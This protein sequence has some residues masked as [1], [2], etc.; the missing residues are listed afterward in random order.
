MMLP[1]ALA[2]ALCVVLIVP[3]RPLRRL[4]PRPARG[5][6]D[7]RAALSRLLRRPAGSR[8]VRG[9]APVAMEFL[10]VCLDAGAPV[11][12]A[13]RSVVEVSPEVTA[14]L[15]GR[16]LAYL[17]VGRAP[18]EAW[19][20]LGDDA[21]WGAAARDFVRSARSGTALSEAL[22]RHA[23]DLRQGDHEEET[24]RAR[25]VGVKSVGPLM[26][27]FLPAFVLVGVIPIIAGLL[28]DFF[29]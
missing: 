4:D 26:G 2:A 11:A 22:R 29:G 17:D 14:S 7:W 12:S 23:A 9:Q 16:V 19:A 13:V 27:C 24:K 15:L 5:A 6:P 20:E 25:T 18:E 28:G 3:G 10:A 1:L 8:A 21:V